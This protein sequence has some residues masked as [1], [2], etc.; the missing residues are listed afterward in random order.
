MTELL[1]KTAR[2]PDIQP[3]PSE[4]DP[5]QLRLLGHLAESLKASQQALLAHDRARLDRLTAEQTLLCQQLSLAATETTQKGCGEHLGSGSEA[6]PSAEIV[7]AHQRVLH[8]GRVQQFLLQRA[9]Q[10][11]R[12]IANLISG[13]RS[14]Y[15]PAPGNRGIELRPLSLDEED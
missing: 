1:S 13:T 14:G 4:F 9:Q 11:L 6:A 8:L 5:H 2:A 3:A 12:V 10:S 7:A 15:V